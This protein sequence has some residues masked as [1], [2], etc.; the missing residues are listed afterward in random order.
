MTAERGLSTASVL[1]IAAAAGLVPLNSTMI[2]VAL[3]QIASDFDMSTG[4]VSILVTVYL[5]AMLIGQPIAGRLGD[6][7]GNQRMVN[8]ALIGVIGCSAVAA[9]SSTF[10]MLAAARVAQAAFSAA[11]GPAVQSLLRS[12]SPPEQSGRAFGLMG[13]V[14][15]VGAASGPVV[16][17]I[18]T[19]AFGWQAIFVFN[20]PVAAAALFVSTRL[21]VGVS[22]IPVDLAAGAMRD[23]TPGDVGRI[24]NPVFASA[25]SVQALS[26]LA[27]YALLLLTPI[28]LDARGWESGRI[29]LVLS[30][31]TVGMIVTGPVGGRLGDK[32]GRRQP[33]QAGLSL[34]AVAVFVL[35]VGGPATATAVL[36]VGLA[37]FGVGL[38]SATPN[39]MTTALESVP[40]RRTGAAAGVLSMSRYVGS[41]VTSVVVSIVVSGDAGGTRV[42]LAVATAAMV[43]A[44]L[45]ANR[46]PSVVDKGQPL[47]LSDRR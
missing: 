35:L 11:L 12:A 19:Q 41:I 32:R 46:F 24:L 17:G 2:A 28:I 3:P 36:V 15:G 44:I 30:A 6:A 16:G 21:D 33:T 10:V 4:R 5:V 18:L 43:T 14:L 47:P 38:G 20:I 23:E 37:A 9:A 34:A 8:L 45:V 1:G 27:Q 25:F 42:V 13:S 39:M 26:T 29:G 7:F 40:P 31:L 22:S